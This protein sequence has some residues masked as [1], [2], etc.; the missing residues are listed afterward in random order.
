MSGLN[1]LWVIRN[2]I[3]SCLLRPTVAHSHEVESSPAEQFLG[4]LFPCLSKHDPPG[5]SVGVFA[6]P[7]HF[8]DRLSDGLE[9]LILSPVMCSRVPVL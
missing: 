9:D 1:K 7:D 4:L 2:G 3:F 8:A 6:L 5:R